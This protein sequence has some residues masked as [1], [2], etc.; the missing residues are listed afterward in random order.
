[1]SKQI[2]IDATTYTVDNRVAAHIL[3]L[4][5]QIFNARSRNVQLDNDMCVLRGELMQSMKGTD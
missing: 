2:I 4:E 5:R 3:E 1:M